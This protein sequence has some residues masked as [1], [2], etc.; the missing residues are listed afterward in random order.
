MAESVVVMPVLREGTA[1]GV[2]EPTVTSAWHPGVEGI[3][4]DA[5]YFPADVTTASSP[6]WFWAAVRV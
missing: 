4:A 1:A 6:V 5:L 3:P 2:V